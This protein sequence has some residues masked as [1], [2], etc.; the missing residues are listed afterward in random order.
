MQPVGWFTS[1]RSIQAGCLLALQYRQLLALM[2]TCS[3]WKLF[4]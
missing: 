4:G 1:L 2:C 3:S